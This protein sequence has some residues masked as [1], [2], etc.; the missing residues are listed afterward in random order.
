MSKISVDIDLVSALADL[1]DEKGLN[2]I[3]LGH[4]EQSLRLS[5]G[6][7]GAVAAPIAVPAPIPTAVPAPAA[8]PA[9]AP[10]LATDAGSSA[11][12]GHPGDVPSPMVGTAYLSPQPGA[13]SFI[14]VGDQV[15]EGQTLLII[16]AMKVMNPIPA[17]KSGK[18]VAI[19]VGDSD[20][21]EF[22]QA[23]VAIE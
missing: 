18:V 14:S 4:G 15:S 3:E 17:P 12:A 7:G 9:P 10:A 11:A 20:P 23:L 8:A 19:Y 21:V 22:G 2:E 6:I 13:D 16:E 5:R 1:M